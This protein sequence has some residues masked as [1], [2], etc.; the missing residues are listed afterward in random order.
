MTRY[1]LAKEYDASEILYKKLHVPKDKVDSLHIP[2]MIISRE[3]LD[4]D[5][6]LVKKELN[7]VDDYENG[8]AN[9]SHKK[10]KKYHR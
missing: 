2:N 7:I 1:K 6:K 9:N 3:I 8:E 5:I 10:G 4:T